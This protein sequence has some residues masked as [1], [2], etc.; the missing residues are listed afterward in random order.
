RRHSVIFVGFKDH[1]SLTMVTLDV[2]GL[3]C[4][5]PYSADAFSG[6]GWYTPSKV[7]NH[8]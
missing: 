6:F 5:W 1:V 7:M 2:S 3:L 4:V 8:R